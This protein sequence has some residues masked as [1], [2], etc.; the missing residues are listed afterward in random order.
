MPEEH[1]DSRAMDGWM[2]DRNRDEHT[3][4]LFFNRH[5]VLWATLDGQLMSLWKKRTVSQCLATFLSLTEICLSACVP[6]CLSVSTVM[7]VGFVDQDRFSEVLFHV[8]SITNVKKQDKGRFSVYFRKKHYDFMA[9]SDGT[10]TA[11]Y[12]T[13]Q[14]P[15]IL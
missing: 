15:V 2:R 10:N 4:C 11:V 7:C 6:V 13:L 12:W 14:H 1:Q 3:F 9:H 8:S 5:N